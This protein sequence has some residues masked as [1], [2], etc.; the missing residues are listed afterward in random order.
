M[1]DPLGI[2][3]ALQAASKPDQAKRQAAS[4]PDA[5]KAQLRAQIDQLAKLEQ[6]VSNSAQAVAEHKPDAI[7]KVE[8][9]L[10]SAEEALKLLGSMAQL[11]ISGTK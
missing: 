8:Q 3:S 11:R 4:D 7:A 9:G 6:M 10:N 5:F 2:I 1:G